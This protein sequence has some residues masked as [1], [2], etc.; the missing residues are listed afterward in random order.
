[1][2]KTDHK[3]DAVTHTGPAPAG[4]G[5]RLAAMA[6]DGLVL[7][8]VLFIAAA[9][10]Q[11]VARLLGFAQPGATVQT[12]EVIHA[13]EPAAVGVWFQLYLCLVIYA[14]FALFWSRSGQT[15]GMIAWRLQ[16]RRPGGGNIGWGQ[17]LIR[18]AGACVSLA[19][20]GAGYWW[21][22]FD[23]DRRT[24]HDRWSRSEVVVLP[25]HR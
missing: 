24:W 4:L 9:V 21:L 11:L 20:A 10:Y 17:A 14:F 3:S 23:R 25:R 1:M 13:I 5:R 18:L 7:F 19:C 8:G 6:Y 15:L 12:G 2:N 16:L 22:W